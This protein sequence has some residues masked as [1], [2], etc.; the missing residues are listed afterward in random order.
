MP[1][2][3]RHEDGL[4]NALARLVANALGAK[5]EYFWWAQR[6]GYVRNTLGAGHCDVLMGVPDGAERMLTTKPYYRSSYVFLQRKGVTPVASLDDPSL[7]SLKI[8]VQLI[9]DDFSNAPPAHS[10]ARRGIID[11]VVG[12]MVYGDYSSPDPERPIIIAV[13]SGAIDLAIVWGPLAGYYAARA[14]VPLEL[15]PVEP[16]IDGSLPMSFAISM[17]VRRK[18]A[19]LRAQ[20]DDVLARKRRD[21]LA[22]LARFGVPQLPAAKSGESQ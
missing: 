15:R 3:N 8:G 19:G 22:L 11:N 18:D 9:G 4:E 14:S 12:F 13:E 17:G 10:L 1:F 5:L 6:R 7:R 21:V 20:L 16:R 2:S